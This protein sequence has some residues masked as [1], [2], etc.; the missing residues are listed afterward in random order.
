MYVGIVMITKIYLSTGKLQVKGQ[1]RVKSFKRLRSFL[2]VNSFPDCIYRSQ[3]GYYTIDSAGTL[4]K[5][6]EHLDRVTFQEVYDIVN[7]L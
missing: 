5:V 2:I 1:D 7:K 3:G 4:K 6:F